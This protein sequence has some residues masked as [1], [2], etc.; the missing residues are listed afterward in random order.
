MPMG[1]NRLSLMDFSSEISPPS[2]LSV[3]Y[4][5][6]GIYITKEVENTERQISIKQLL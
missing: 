5:L 1:R 3:S 2:C 4:D 6:G